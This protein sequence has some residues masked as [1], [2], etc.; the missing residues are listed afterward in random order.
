MLY[1][2]KFIEISLLLQFICE[3]IIKEG[4]FSFSFIAPRFRIRALDQ[5]LE[6]LSNFEIDLL[7]LIT[8][9]STFLI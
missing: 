7:F 5:S 4:F 8:T 2:K 1:I 6:I 3:I 9:L